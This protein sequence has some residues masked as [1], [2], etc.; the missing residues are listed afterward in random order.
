MIYDQ[1][2]A[3]LSKGIAKNPDASIDYLQ[4]SDAAKLPDGKH[5]VAGGD[6]VIVQTPHYETKNPEDTKFEAYKKYIDIQIVVGGCYYL[7]L[8]GL[9][10]DGPFAHER[11]AGFYKGENKSCFPLEAGMFAL[12]FPWDAHTPSCDYAGEKSKIHK[13]ILKV[14]V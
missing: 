14:L 12:F 4:E 6:A 7:S 8:S 10:E 5:P 1:T 13:I 11:D 9:T 2:N 3:F